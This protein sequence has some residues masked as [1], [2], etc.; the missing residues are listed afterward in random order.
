MPASQGVGG[1]TEM[2]RAV[3]RSR[4]AVSSRSSS[5][6]K[7]VTWLDLVRNNG[8][9]SLPQVLNYESLKVQPS[10]AITA[11][12]SQEQL[13]TGGQEQ[14]GGGMTETCQLC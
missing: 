11:F 2:G 7:E 14:G 13:Y 6:Y 8:L 5:E 10:S 1:D 3:T 4:G 9:T 12:Q